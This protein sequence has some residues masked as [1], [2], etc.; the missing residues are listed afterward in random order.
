MLIAC[1]TSLSRPLRLYMFFV[2]SF[3]FSFFVIWVYMPIVCGMLSSRPLRLD[4]ILFFSIFLFLFPFPFFFSFFLFFLFDP[5]D[6]TPIACQTL[7]SLQLTAFFLFLFFPFS[8]SFLFFQFSFTASDCTLITCSILLSK[9]LR[10][11]ARIFWCSFF[12]PPFPLT[13]LDFERWLLVV[14]GTLSSRP[15]Q[16]DMELP[17]LF[18]PFFVLF[19][20]PLWIVR[21]LLVIHLSSQPLRLDFWTFYLFSFS[22]YRFELYDD[23]LWYIMVTNHSDFGSHIHVLLPRKESTRGKRGKIDFLGKLIKFPKISVVPALAVETI[24]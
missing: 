19:I 15:L 18:F 5:L 24:T 9:P 16:L 13:A 6:H 1:G 22:F 23:C 21:R 2:L 12:F 10:L 8:F 7:S 11:D 20:L 17:P 3:S 14:R 4:M